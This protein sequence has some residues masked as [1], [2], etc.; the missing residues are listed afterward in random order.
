MCV[1]VNVLKF[2]LNIVTAAGCSCEQAEVRAPSRKVKKKKEKSTAE[3]KLTE[4]PKKL[5]NVDKLSTLAIEQ[6]AAP[7]VDGSGK[8]S[9]ALDSAEQKREMK[10]KKKRKEKQLNDSAVPGLGAQAGLAGKISWQIN[11]EH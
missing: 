1:H 9:V 11:L 10:K 3:T 6:S 4:D 8:T 5:L 7:V 2:E